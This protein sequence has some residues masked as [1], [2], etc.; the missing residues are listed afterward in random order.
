MMNI[1]VG[2]III[3]F[4]KEGEQEFKN[5]ELDKN[6]VTSVIFDVLHMWF[7]LGIC[8]YIQWQI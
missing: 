6:Q 3:T 1:F 5:C 2:F 8:V 4:Q 7:D